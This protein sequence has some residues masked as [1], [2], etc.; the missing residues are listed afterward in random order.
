MTSLLLATPRRRGMR[1]VAGRITR[2]GGDEKARREVVVI[3]DVGSPL[4]RQNSDRRRVWRELGWP[5][6]ASEADEAGGK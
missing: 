1:Q 2:K 3:R 5:A 4:D 6:A